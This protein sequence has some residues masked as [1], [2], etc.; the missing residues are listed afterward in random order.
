MNKQTSNKQKNSPFRNKRISVLVYVLVLLLQHP[1]LVLI[2]K[3]KL[4]HSLSWWLDSV[5]FLFF[6][7]FFSNSCFISSS[8]S[9]LWQFKFVCCFLAPEFNFVA[10]QLSCFGVGFSLCWFTGGLFLYLTPF[11]WSKVSDPSASPL[12]SVC[13]DGL[14][15][16]F[17]FC[18]VVWL[19]VLLTGSGDKLC[20]QLPALFQAVAYHQHAIGPSVFPAFV[21]WKFPWRSAPC[22]SPLL[23]CAFSIPPPL[24]WVSFQFLVYC[25]VFVLFCFVGGGQSAQ[26]HIL[27][28]PRGGWGNAVWHLAL[29][30]LVCQMSP[31]R[32]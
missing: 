16:V 7:L 5:F 18:S 9:V 22:S 21:Y 14:L 28:Y 13:C 12:L 27:I 30:C 32:S 11:P 3:Q 25:S 17:H 19:W 23:W 8:L 6:L 26:G 2:F 1:V 24:L 31:S 10:Y 15:I 20:G 29:P 4:C